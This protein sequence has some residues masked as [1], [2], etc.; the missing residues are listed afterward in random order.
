MSGMV[1]RLGRR[2]ME[3][4]PKFPARYDDVARWWLNAV[5]AELEDMED[6]AHA[7]CDDASSCLR[8]EA[9]S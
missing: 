3:E 4:P 5:A 1:E 6:A 2:W 7:W 8:F 9:E